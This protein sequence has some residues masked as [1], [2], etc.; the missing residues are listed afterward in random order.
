MQ[1]LLQRLHRRQVAGHR[2][3][4]FARH[5]LGAEEQLQ[6]GL[7]AE[8][9]QCRTQRLGLDLEGFARLCGLAVDGHGADRQGQ[10]QGA[11]A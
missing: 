7:L 4:L 1:Q 10:R 11:Q 6:V 5:Q 9:V 8:L 3:G 2:R